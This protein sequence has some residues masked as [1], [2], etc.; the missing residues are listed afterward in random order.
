MSCR[1]AEVTPEPHL[2]GIG[3]C[4]RDLCKRTGD[5]PWASWDVSEHAWGR[6]EAEKMILAESRL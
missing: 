6:P 2:S 3:R 1:E 5:C 4:L